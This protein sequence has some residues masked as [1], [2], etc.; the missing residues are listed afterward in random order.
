MTLLLNKKQG[1]SLYTECYHWP[2]TL[3]APFKKQAVLALLRYYQNVLDMVFSTDSIEARQ[4]YIDFWRKQFDDYRAY[5][6][7]FTKDPLRL[8]IQ[9][10]HLPIDLLETFFPAVETSFLIKHFDQKQGLDNEID[11]MSHLTSKPLCAMIWTV[12]APHDPIDD[13]FCDTL[14]KAI[15]RLSLIHLYPEMI[16]RQEIYDLLFQSRLL[17]LNQKNSKLTPV[18]KIIE[19]NI[20]VLKQ[21]TFVQRIPRLPLF[22]KVLLT[23]LR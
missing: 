9:K 3:L 19:L 16:E 7:L 4:I 8:A 18:L 10:H 1:P 21:Q 6:T 14:G 15:L 20:K 22:Q 5:P 11:S 12:F 2:L 13:L 17:L 23:S